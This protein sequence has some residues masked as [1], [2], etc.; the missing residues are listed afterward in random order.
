ME[1]ARR[2]RVI[3]ATCALLLSL[4]AHC[5][6]LGLA[7][8]L[9]RIPRRLA[10]AGAIRISLLAPGAVEAPAGSAP[11][12][13]AVRHAVHAASSKNDI[14]KPPHRVERARRKRTNPKRVIVR[15]PAP[16]IRTPA[17]VRT[18]ERKRAAASGAS[19]TA[20]G[21]ASHGAPSLGGRGIISLG[22]RPIPATAVAYP[23]RILKRVLPQYPWR[24]RV[25][26]I[27][28]QV[29]LEVLL[30]RDGTIRH[31]KILRSVALLDEAAMRAVRQWR[32][33]PARNAQGKT[34]SVIVDIPVVFTLQD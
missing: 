30:G 6:V 12:P 3:R 24:A 7:I 9:V 5:V 29:L 31:I 16:K 28:G 13:G 22:T 14:S 20:V 8:W 27:S 32:F 21:K 34:V 11:S 26:G 19:A 4:S 2:R 15:R 1:N 23:P 17:Q 10:P 25:R 33:S 18:V